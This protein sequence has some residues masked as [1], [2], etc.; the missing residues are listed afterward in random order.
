MKKWFGVLALVSLFVL[1]SVPMAFSAPSD[2]P[3][4]LTIANQQIQGSTY[5]FDVL[6]RFNGTPIDFKPG[7]LTLWILYNESALDKS[8][9]TLSKVVGV[10]CATDW[11][12]DIDPPY[13]ILR[14]LR[15][16]T[17]IYC[18][19]HPVYPNCLAIDTI[20][21][22]NDY[23]AVGYTNLS[24]LT[25]ADRNS[26]LCRVK[27]NILDSEKPFGVMWDTRNWAVNRIMPNNEPEITSTTGDRL[28]TFLME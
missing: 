16:G 22:G 24:P 14:R 13:K 11:Y 20:L 27:I 18:D 1:V 12:I 4:T 15:Q 17:D 19:P 8:S 26:L 7:D 5:Y 23:S 6:L 10:Q 3:V 2:Y 25:A 28:A 9:L 21:L